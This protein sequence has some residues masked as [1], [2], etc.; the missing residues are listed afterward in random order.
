MKKSKT[1]KGITLIALIITIIVLLILAV[2]AIGA[3][4]NDGIIQYAKNAR[5][6]YELAQTNEQAI[7][8]NYL[9][10]LDENAGSST[11]TGWTQSGR[12]VT[13]GTKTLNL[14]DT[15]SYDETKGGTVEVPVDTNWKVLGAEN[16]KILLM[17]TIEVGEVELDGPEDYYNDV[18]IGKINAACEGY[19]KGIGADEVT[20]SRSIKI[21]DIDRIAG[22]DR[23]TYG[24]GQISEY[25]NEVTYTL[26]TDGDTVTVEV[27]GKPDLKETFSLAEVE[28]GMLYSDGPF[29]KP[30]GSEL[31]PGETY[32][33]EKNTFFYP[34]YHLEQESKYSPN[35]IN[36]SLYELLF[37]DGNNLWY[38]SYYVASS[39]ANANGKC[40]SF[41]CVQRF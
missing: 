23:T 22:V 33:A 9:T 16:G 25:G 1:Q 34:D 24:K 26:G 40:C 8:G 17:S 27:K 18:G 13:N 21:E 14:G 31:Q 29:Y 35:G 37:C 4:Q 19:N 32:E 3:V 7:L 38:T 11:S 39:Y 12:T 2:V 30:D 6:E 20:K 10:K 36:K 28:D 5:N 15:V 41:R